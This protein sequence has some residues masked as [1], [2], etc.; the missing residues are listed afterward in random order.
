MLLTRLARDSAV[1]GGAE[2]VTKL[3]SF[4]AF[5]VVAAALS[6]N[7]LGALELILAISGLL[8]LLVNCGVNNAVARFYWDGETDAVQRVSIVTSGI[9]IQIFLGVLTVLFMSICIRF[10]IPYLAADDLPLSWVALAGALV[11]MVVSQWV[12]YALDVTRLHFA[13][14]RFFIIAILSRV[15]VIIMGILAVILLKW[16]VDGFLIGQ[17][18]GLLLVLPISFWLIRRDIDISK[19]DFSR[20]RQLFGFGYPFIFA[21]TAYWLFGSMDRWMLASMTSLE[22]VGIYS[23]AFRFSSLALF[24]S[25]AFGQ[26]WNPMVIKFRT[27]NP[28][29]YRSVYGN[30]LL[31][32]F[33]FMFVVG[34]GVALFSGEIIALIMPVEYLSASLPLAILCFSAIFQ[35]TQQ[36]TAIGISLERKTY[37]LAR[38]AWVTAAVNLVGN[39]LLIPVFGAAGA[40]WSTLVSNFFLTASFLLFT[41]RLH[42]LVIPWRRLGVVFCLISFVA[43][44]SFS[45]MVSNLDPLVISLKLGAALIAV[46]FGLSIV[47]FRFGKST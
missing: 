17:A 6:A 19:F 10:S 8:G 15:I 26:A 37:L 42:P 2:V 13:H 9:S 24:F 39:W 33:F 27:E 36:V 32:L 43:S 18:F 22:E 14:W 47:R 30:I 11:V 20:S 46:G 28:D 31:L 7:A 34:G 3:L 16:G 38:L 21:G 5:P 25:V 12:Q 23:V 44:V 41:Q 40:A 45:M 35:A 29:S 1:Y 4:M